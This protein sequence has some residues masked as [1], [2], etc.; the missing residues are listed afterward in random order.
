MRQSRIDEQA[1]A[2]RR[3]KSGEAE[4]WFAVALASK[5]SLRSRGLWLRTLTGRHLLLFEFLICRLPNAASKRLQSRLYVYEFDR[6]G[7][8]QAALGR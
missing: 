4:K 7:R 6:S 1:L 2:G 8:F 5:R 3:R